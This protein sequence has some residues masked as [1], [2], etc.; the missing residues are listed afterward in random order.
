MIERDAIF[1][2]AGWDGEKKIDIIK[3]SA[4]DA[5]SAL[6]PTRDKVKASIA[7]EPLIEAE[8]EQK[9]LQRLAAAEAS[10]PPPAVK[11]PPTEEPTDKDS[12]LANFF[13]NLLKDKPAGGKTIAPPTADTAAQLD[14]ILKSAA[15]STAK[16]EDVDA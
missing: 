3:E 7:R 11:K 2:P 10:A 6:E 13:S 15:S 8:D 1:V 16:S 4:P 9:F 14:R 5:D 12:P